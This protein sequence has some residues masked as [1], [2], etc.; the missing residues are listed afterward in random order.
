M[1]ARFI[2]DTEGANH[3]LLQVVEMAPLTQQGEKAPFPGRAKEPAELL[4]RFDPGVFGQ[5]QLDGEGIVGVFG[6]NRRKYAVDF[7]AEFSRR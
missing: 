4:D 1:D 7:G 2:K 5:N 6:P 3:I